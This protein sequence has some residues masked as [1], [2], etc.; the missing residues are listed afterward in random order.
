MMCYEK[1]DF[2]FRKTVTLGFTHFVR[3]AFC[4]WVEKPRGY[5]CRSENDQN[6]TGWWLSPT[7][8]TKYME[9]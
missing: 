1:C 5:T 3:V 4:C 2:P 8:R 9:T 7:P 6:R